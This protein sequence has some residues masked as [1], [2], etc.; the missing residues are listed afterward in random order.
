MRK[1]APIREKTIP[2]N[3]FKV[4]G[5]ERNIKPLNTTIIKLPTRIKGKVIDTALLFE[6]K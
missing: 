2:N 5:S 4:M 3:I 1:K 6:S